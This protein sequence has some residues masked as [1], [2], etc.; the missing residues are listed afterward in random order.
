M[1]FRSSTI[2]RFFSSIQVW[3]LALTSASLLFLTACSTNSHANW[4]GRVGNYTYD[5]AVAELGPPKSTQVK[6]DG[7]RVAEWLAQKG[8]PG[9]VGFGMDA[10]QVTPGIRESQVPYETS[11]VPDQYLRLT[12]GSDGRLQSWRQ[13]AR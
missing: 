9:S 5:Q 7:T 6:P 4:N 13:S 3:F 10:G 8:R 12:F 1:N 11:R 2:C